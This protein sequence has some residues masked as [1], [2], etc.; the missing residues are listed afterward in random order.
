V[1]QIFPAQVK[2]VFILIGLGTAAVTGLLAGLAPAA[3]A[4]RLAPVE[5][6]RY[7]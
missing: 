5:A 1:N 4:A 3:A 2:L 7:E 6:L